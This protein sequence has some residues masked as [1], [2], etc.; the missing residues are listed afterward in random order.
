M[1]AEW[2]TDRKGCCGGDHLTGAKIYQPPNSARHFHCPSLLHS[3][4]S[5]WLSLINQ[6]T[7]VGEDVENGNPHALLVPMHIG[8]AT[9]ENS[10]ELSQKVKNE[11][12]L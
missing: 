9:M 7:S 1:A 5:E 10:M 2:K 8:A 4:L 3:L 11:T 6:Q 12:A